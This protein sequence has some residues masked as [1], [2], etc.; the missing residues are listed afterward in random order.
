MGLIAATN[1]PQEVA[2][3]EVATGKELQRVTLDNDVLAARFIPS[4]KQLLVLTATQK[5]YELSLPAAGTG[6]AK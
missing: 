1:R 3:Y 2:I 5:V 4:K 6:A